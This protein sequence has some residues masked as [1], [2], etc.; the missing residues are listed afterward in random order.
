MSGERKRVLVVDDSVFARR[1]VSDII[2][3]SKDL[4]VVGTAINGIDALEQLDKLKPDVITMDG[5]C[6]SSTG[7]RLSN[8]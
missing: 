3:T 7:L 2:G 4:E 6:P 1:I 5:R 8:A